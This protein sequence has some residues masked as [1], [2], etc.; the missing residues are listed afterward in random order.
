MA[1]PIPPALKPVT[2]YVRRAE[3]LDQAQEAEAP[4]VAYYCRLYATEQAMKLQGSGK[5][6]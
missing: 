1:M 5:D 6:V 2:Q 4:V 3:R